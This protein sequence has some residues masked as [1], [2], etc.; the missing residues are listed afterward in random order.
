[1]N[2]APEIS[3]KEKR[4]IIQK[5]PPILI[6]EPTNA[7]NANC[8]IC[9]RHQMTRPIGYLQ[10]TLFTKIIDE[11]AEK[12][13][14]EIRL[15]NFGEPTLHPQL[16]QMIAYCRD[17][18]LRVNIQTNG[19]IITPEMAEKLTAAGLDYIGISVNGL[20][21]QE[22][23][24]I[25]PGLQLD[26]LKNRLTTLKQWSLATGTPLHI[27]INAQILKEEV[28][29]RDADIREFANQWSAIADTLSISGLS[30]YDAVILQQ[31]GQSEKIEL[32]HLQRKPDTSVNCTEPFDRL[33]I[34][35][36]GT[37]TPC[38]ADFD[39]RMVLGD[40]NTQ[41]IETIWNSPRLQNLRRTILAHEYSRIP[42]CRSCPKF[43]SDE[44]T[45]VFR[46]G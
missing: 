28:S 20:T 8:L 46:K 15:F 9:P 34:K 21:Q 5:I 19:L 42:L 6:I 26:Q 13:S 11:A 23:S 41:S 18:Q 10:W 7:C 35:W 3:I 12:G 36:D 4:N 39:A 33:V 17:K 25:R 43:Y 29:E 31:G 30:R 40:L 32:T 45:I 1:M 37:A 44:F 24:S 22:Y 27:H 14:P 2:G 38:C 16:D